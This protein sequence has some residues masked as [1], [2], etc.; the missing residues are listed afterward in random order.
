MVRDFLLLRSASEGR[1]D[2]KDKLRNHT[3]ALKNTKDEW[4]THCSEKKSKQVP[5]DMGNKAPAPQNPGLFD[6]LGLSSKG[7]KDDN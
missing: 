3:A 6:C 2:D 5:E 1:A 4:K 7:M